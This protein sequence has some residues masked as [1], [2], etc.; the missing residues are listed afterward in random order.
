M[1]PP[2]TRPTTTGGAQ[3]PKWT[4]QQVLD[5]FG[6]LGLPVCDDGGLIAQK[7]TA[8]RDYYM[9]LLRK[10]DPKQREKGEAG[11]KGGEALQNRR[12]ELLR[13]VFEEFQA[14][15]DTALAGFMAAGED[16]L[17][18]PI[19]DQ[20]RNHLRTKCRTD[21]ALTT[22]FLDEYINGHGFELATYD[23]N[24]LIYRKE[25]LLQP[26]LHKKPASA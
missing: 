18:A 11:V 21:D 5:M 24:S 14:W 23:I 3:A 16:T 2:Q 20:L 8:K 17:T 22:R 10:P 13:V 25:Q 19:V 1:P 12:P 4:L 7:F 6:E 15:A 9:S 26:E